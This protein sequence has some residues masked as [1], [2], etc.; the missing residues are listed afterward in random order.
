[1]TTVEQLAPIYA[2]F[3]PSSSDNLNFKARIRAGTLKLPEISTIKVHLVLEN[4]TPYE[5]TG[6]LDFT[7]RTVDPTTGGQTIRALFPNPDQLLLP[8]QFVRG[9]ID[10]GVIPNGIRIPQRAV[11]LSD[12]QASVTVVNPDETVSIRAVELGDMESSDWVINSGLHAGDRAI[13]DG[14]Q[15]IQPGQKVRARALEMP[16]QPPAASKTQS[17][18]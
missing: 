18:R 7:D 1:M 10:A 17:L 15:K 4:G 16:T 6:H 9:R 13:I 3:A 8:G 2:T 5:P 14:W 11:Q 12:K